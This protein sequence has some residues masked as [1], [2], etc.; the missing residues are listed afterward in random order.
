MCCALENRVK[1][2]LITGASGAIGQAIALKLAKQGIHLYLH[3]HT[4]RKAIDQI[5]PKL[6]A[7]GIDVIP[8]QADFS[9]LADVKAVQAELFQVDLFIH[10]AGNSYYQLFQ[11][12]DLDMLDALWNIH[13]RFPVMLL[14]GI[15]P[16][17]LKNKKGRI[18][19]ISSIWGEIG[20]SMEVA[21]STVKGAQIAFC[22]ALSKEI[23]SSGVTVNVVSPGYIDTEMNKSF[24]D[25]EKQAIQAEIPLKKFGSSLDV[26]EAVAFLASS[27]SSYITGQVLRINGGW[28]M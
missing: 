20:A 25:F 17:L 5:T 28:L 15:L 21:Y 24:D 6:L 4:N 1:Y 22:R 11:D 3:Y 23:A 2:A 13:V 16:K 10:A 26:A 9:N 7:E 14:Q 8:I 12:T 27:A 18:I 19:F